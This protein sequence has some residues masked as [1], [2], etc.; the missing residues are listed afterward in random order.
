MVLIVLL[1]LSYL[2]EQKSF[3]D[4]YQAGN[5]YKIYA[6]DKAFNY[7]NEA[8]VSDAQLGLTDYSDSELKLFPNPSHS[9]FNIYINES[10]FDISIYD[11]LG[12]MV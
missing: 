9:I 11:I 8:V 12:Q 6:V 3:M 1:V 4:N 5:F 7:S 10:E 2:L